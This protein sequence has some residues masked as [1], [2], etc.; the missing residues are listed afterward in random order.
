TLISSRMLNQVRMQFSRFKDVR[1]DVQPSLYVQ[2]NGYSAEGATYGPRGFGANPESTWEGAD[3]LS[4]RAGT[5]TF[6]AGGGMK[7]VR[8]H[9][10]QLTFERG[11]YYFARARS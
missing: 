4:Y 6:K 11:A 5:H 9:T 3:T 10:D 2:R 7:Y 8:L 1:A